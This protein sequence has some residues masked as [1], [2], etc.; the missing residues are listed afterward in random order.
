[1]AEEFLNDLGM[2][3]A[4]E[5]VGGGSVPE[6]VDPDSWEGGLIEGSMKPLRCPGSVNWSSDWRRKDE[7][8]VVPLRSC[9]QLGR[10]REYSWRRLM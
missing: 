6:V 9:G 2:N 1:V 5:Q 7:S 10:A 3:A 8:G 4:V